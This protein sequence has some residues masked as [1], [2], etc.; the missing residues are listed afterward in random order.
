MNRALLANSAQMNKMDSVYGVYICLTCK[1]S[2]VRSQLSP[3]KENESVLAGSF[4]FHEAFP[5][6]GVKSVSGRKRYP[7]FR[8]VFGIL[9]GVILIA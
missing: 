3:P 7:L 5:Y 9:F 4:V 6:K 1:G 8:S 2:L